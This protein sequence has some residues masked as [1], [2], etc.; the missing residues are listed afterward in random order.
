MSTVAGA[1]SSGLSTA[2]SAV[3]NFWGWLTG[4]SIWPD[5]LN[6]MTNTTKTGMSKTA[7]AFQS[8]LTDI[9]NATSAAISFLQAQWDAFIGY[10]ENTFTPQWQGALNAIEASFNSC[11]TS[12]AAI[13]QQVMSQIVSQVTSA[14]G[15]IQSAVKSSGQALVYGSIWPD[16]LDTMKAQTASAMGNIVGQFGGMSV[17]VPSLLAKGVGGPAPTPVAP[18]T[19]QQINVPVSVRVDSTKVAQLLEKR[20]VT[21]YRYGAHNMRG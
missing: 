6:Q 11:F 19:S 16:I 3:S 15:S 13:C 12:M 7:T 20:L 8:S 17:A 18:V 2:T 1:I 4:H 14:L 21:E 10:V 5:G 9:S